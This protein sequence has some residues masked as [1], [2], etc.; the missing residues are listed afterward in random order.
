M[1]RIDEKALVAAFEM[2][3]VKIRSASV[4]EGTVSLKVM[5]RKE[6][7]AVISCIAERFRYKWNEGQEPRGYAPHYMSANAY[8][9]F[10][11]I[12]LVEGPTK[13]R[14]CMACVQRRIK[15]HYS[16]LPIDVEEY[17]LPSTVSNQKRVRRD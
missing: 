11:E 6:Y 12:S 7:D 9:L 16:T 13:S 17:I 5:N 15:G 3:V 14:C 8:P 1:K 2:A 10:I 4:R